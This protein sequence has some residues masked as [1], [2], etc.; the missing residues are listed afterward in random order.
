MVSG[1][2]LGGDG[3][4][5]IVDNTAYKLPKPLFGIHGVSVTK[6]DVY[7]NGYQLVRGKWKITLKSLFYLFF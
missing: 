6:R 7:V 4:F 1:V 5:I 3:E 2:I